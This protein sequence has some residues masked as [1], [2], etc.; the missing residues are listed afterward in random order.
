VRLILSLGQGFSHNWHRHCQI[1]S[2]CQ[3]GI[4]RP[5]VGESRHATTNRYKH[6]RYSYHLIFGSSVRARA[7]SPTLVQHRI[8]LFSSFISL[9]TAVK[10][11][12]PVLI[13][14]TL[15]KQQRRSHRTNSV[16]FHQTLLI[17][18][19]ANKSYK[20]PACRDRQENKC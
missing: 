9:I 16:C 14:L 19:N 15:C 18:L 11:F 20:Q 1:W 3:I 10:L 7:L 13:R 5:H 17:P 12:G 2:A 8:P 6:K 4:A